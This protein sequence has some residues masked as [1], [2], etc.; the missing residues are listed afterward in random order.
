[1]AI[2]TTDDKH[3]RQ[4]ADALRQKGEPDK[5][6][7]P[8]EMADGIYSACDAQ[9]MMGIAEGYSMGYEAQHII[10]TGTFTPTQ[11][12]NSVFLEIPA[13]A[14]MVEIIPQGTPSASAGTSRMPIHYVFASKAFQDNNKALENQGAGVQYFYGSRIYTNFYTFDTTSGFAV[15]CDPGL[16][17]EA[18][19]TYQWRAHYWPE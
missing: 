3:Y 12:T 4:I 16:V 17:F 2:V 11:D 15:T 8:E 13:K 14:K 18:N 5:Q 1:M 9:Y 10:K 7:T 6:Y 19:M